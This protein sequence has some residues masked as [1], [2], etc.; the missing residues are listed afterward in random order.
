MSGSDGSADCDGSAV[1]RAAGFEECCAQVDVR[2]Q[3]CFE[4]PFECRATADGAAC[5][6]LLQLLPWFLDDNGYSSRAERTFRNTFYIFLD[7]L[8][9]TFPFISLYFTLTALI[10]EL[11]TG[12]TNR[13]RGRVLI[14]AMKS[15]MS[16]DSE[17]QSG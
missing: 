7:G 17:L 2:R 16:D 11:N 6:C 1:S 12:L 3:L 10:F 4:Y 13:F 15:K 9:G 8:P 14:E 5:S